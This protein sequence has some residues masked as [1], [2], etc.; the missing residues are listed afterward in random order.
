MAEVK[1]EP[2]AAQLVDS[3]VAEE[4][5]AGAIKFY[6]TDKHDPAGFHFQCPCGCRSVGAVRVA[7]QPAWRWNG[8]REKPTVTP[9]V[10]LFDETRQPHWHGYLTDGVWRSC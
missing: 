4:A 3:I 10:L 1:T 7:G 8:D 2:V 5:P 6:K 9:S